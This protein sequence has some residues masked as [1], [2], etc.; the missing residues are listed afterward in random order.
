MG[1]AFQAWF[2]AHIDKANPKE[3]FS[4]SGWTGAGA[5]AGDVES[6]RIVCGGRYNAEAAKGKE[7]T[8]VEARDCG[9]E[10]SAQAAAQVEEQKAKP[11]GKAQE[12]KAK[13]KAIA[14]EKPRQ[15]KK[16]GSKTRTLHRC[17][18]PLVPQASRHNP[19]TPAIN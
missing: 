12:K 7:G 9:K 15:P 8:A 14:K 6:A 1:D 13:A 16:A 19:G 18:R 11:K 17:L 5:P 3:Y 4:R 10:M 2:A